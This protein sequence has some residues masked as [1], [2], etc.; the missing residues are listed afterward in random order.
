MTDKPTRTG[1]RAARIADQLRA[2]IISGAFAPG[3][4][5]RQE[6]L[7][8]RFQTSRMPVRDSFRI[9]QQEGLVEMPANRGA[10]VAPLDAASFREIS[11]MR[12]VAEALALKHAIPELSNRQIDL[13]A[14]IQDEAE[15][16][17]TA[18]FGDLNK[19]FHHALLAPC[20][21]PRLL[22]HIA[23]LN[24]L[25]ERY[26]RFAV[27]ELDYAERSHAEHRALLEACNRRDSDTACAL[28]TAHIDA[29]SQG[30]LAALRKQLG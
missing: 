20:G 15:R 24:D 5:L 9:L 21:W 19:A 30:L 13:A 25:T 8:Q 6:D 17:D 29:A 26:L 22:S 28:L 1:E 11:E 4:S 23:G 12:V 3:E 2:D 10:R 16:A 7:A 27:D 14:S 18:Q